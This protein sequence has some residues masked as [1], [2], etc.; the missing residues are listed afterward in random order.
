LKKIK[1]IVRIEI[2][3]QNNAQ[4]AE[5]NT[6][7]FGEELNSEEN[8]T[9]PSKENKRSTYN[10]FV[11]LRVK[12]FWLAQSVSKRWEKESKDGV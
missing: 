12:E 10:G 5:K 7:W 3:W 1:T 4:F 9:Q 2:L 8:I 11:Y 6:S